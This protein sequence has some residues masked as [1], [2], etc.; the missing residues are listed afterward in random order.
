MQP[1]KPPRKRVS[2]ACNLCR[3]RKVRCI[4][5]NPAGPCIN[6]KH[7]EKHCS[8][9][10]REGTRPASPRSCSNN[11]PTPLST[12]RP[13]T[14]T[15][16]PDTTTQPRHIQPSVNDT[17]T[18]PKR[19]FPQCSDAETVEAPESS[20]ASD[21]SFANLFNAQDLDHIF[22]A[23]KEIPKGSC[24]P[25]YAFLE[26][27]DTQ[28]LLSQ[29]LSFLV[30]QGCFI[31]PHR[32]AL[33]E[34]MRQY[35]LH[36]HPMLP[37]L[38]EKDHWIS[39]NSQDGNV[40]YKMPILVLQGLLFISSG[41]L[42]DFNCEKS[43]IAIAQAALLLA[44]SH[45]IPRC[46]AGN[47]PMGS[48]WL[49]IAITYARD[50]K[51]HCHI[52][53][54]PNNLADQ[55]KARK[56]QN[57]LK[58]LWWCCIICDRLLPLTSRQNIKI[59]KS[60]FNFSGCS[61]LGSADLAEE[62]FSSEVYDST[63]KILHAEILSK[64]VELCVV[65][66]DVLTFTSVF[67]NNPSWILSGRI[68]G[69]NLCQLELEH[70]YNSWTE[71]RSTIEERLA[72]NDYPQSPATSTFLFTNLIE[73]YYHSARVSICHYDL[74]RSNLLSSSQSE[75]QLCKQKNELQGAASRVTQCLQEL[76]RMGLTRWLPMTALGCTAFPLAL[77][78]IDVELLRP[79]RQK[80]TTSQTIV[81][82]LNQKQQQVKILL[83]TMSTYRGHYYTTDWIMNTIKHVVNIARDR[84]P[85]LPSATGGSNSSL[86]SWGDMLQAQP[87]YY[88]KLAMTVDL[89][90]SH[91]KLPD[92]CDFPIPLQQGSQQ[93]VPK[94]YSYLMSKFLG[95]YS[96]LGVSTPGRLVTEITPDEEC[97]GKDMP[98]SQNQDTRV[99]DLDAVTGEDMSQDDKYDDVPDL[100][101]TFNEATEIPP[102]DLDTTSFMISINAEERNQFPSW[103]CDSPS[104]G[105]AAWEQFE[106]MEGIDV[107]AQLP[108]DFLSDLNTFPLEN[109]DRSDAPVGIPVDSFVM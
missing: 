62:S 67:H 52:S 98:P 73:M 46:L 51:A 75:M 100:T 69:A 2:K 37:I 80:P 22:S 1:V 102:L 60:N 109:Y 68:G 27:P 26:F 76:D 106:A 33:D 11:P 56:L 74:L 81:L 42:Y 48:I 38:N 103:P 96:N 58:R 107:D 47:K 3:A 44:H 6:C 64:L 45:I 4:L 94:S 57:T 15:R 14:L 108:R 88:L 65:L 35:F 79:I 86:T 54:K 12:E 5:D 36:V 49:G 83:E 84:P 95:G 97:L 23:T 32:A 13:S 59:T 101:T 104:N 25:D 63:T 72:E 19:S 91:G 9:N 85:S 82:S 66:T 71:I 18:A 50:A 41:L 92:E 29:D 77:N 61:V 40:P 87:S 20:V 90:I 31:V 39:Y 16:S 30:A 55:P 34:F 89:G 70:W 7:N 8:F 17:H 10:R 93:M 21:E 43:S 99:I 78:M 24:H 28:D 53:K 105:P